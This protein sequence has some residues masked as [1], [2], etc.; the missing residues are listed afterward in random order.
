MHFTDTL[1]RAYLKETLVNTEILEISVLDH[2]ISDKQIERFAKATANDITL[3]LL[4]SVVMSGWPD[5]KE[6]TPTKIHDY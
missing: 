3:S 4:H 2:M 1:S 6:S 5:T